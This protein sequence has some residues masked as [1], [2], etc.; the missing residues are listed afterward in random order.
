MAV[1][2]GVRVGRT[3]LVGPREWV[4]DR[5]GSLDLAFLAVDSGPVGE[6]IGLVLLVECADLDVGVLRGLLAERIEAVPRLRRRLVRVPVGCG[7]PI[8][9]DDATFDIAGHVRGARCPDPGDERA[10][11]DLA[12]RVIAAPLPTLSVLAR[13]A[14]RD[15]WGGVRRGMDS[16]RQLRISIAAG[17]GLRPMRAAAC[18]LLHPTGPRIRLDVIAVDRVPLRAAARRHGAT[19]NDA[20]LVAV[21]AAL[22]RVVASR[23]KSLDRSRSRSPCRSARRSR[24]RPAT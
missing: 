18:S 4:V 5:A 14:L 24:R 22:G 7:R 11:L 10:L 16:I 20:L 15:K 19:T 2:P 21:A 9:V 23:G 8:C 6:Q 12:A 13:D 17:G 1:S 3:G